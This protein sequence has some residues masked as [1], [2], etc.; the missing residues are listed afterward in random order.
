MFCVKCGNALSQGSRKCN[1]CGNPV[2]LRTPTKLTQKSMSPVTQHDDDNKGV[3]VSNNS[4]VSQV[5]NI[6]TVRIASSGIHDC[7]KCGSS[8]VTPFNSANTKSGF[9]FLESCCGFILLGP[10]GVL[11]GMNSKVKTVNQTHWMCQVC[12]NQFRDP[13]EFLMEKRSN[14]MK[15]AITM[16]VIGAIA[17]LLTLI[18]LI[19]G[20]NVWWLGLIG[21]GLVVVGIWLINKAR[22]IVV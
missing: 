14:M 10:L 9:S 1:N 17:L 19:D 13:T 15:G 16:I 4:Q 12:G 21:I 20:G 5:V 11:C 3:V 6:P 8:N 2:K 22:D 7:N 18:A